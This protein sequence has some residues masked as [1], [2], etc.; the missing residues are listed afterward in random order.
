MSNLKEYDSQSIYSKHNNRSAIEQNKSD[1]YRICLVDN[2]LNRYIGFI[3]GSPKLLGDF[4]SEEGAPFILKAKL[5]F[6]PNVGDGIRVQ[7][8]NKFLEV[9]KRLF[10][11]ILSKKIPSYV[12][13]FVNYT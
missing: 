13:L 3:E 12:F 4:D 11:V 1:E 5:Q 7:G 10:D 6:I 8:I 2:K 9:K